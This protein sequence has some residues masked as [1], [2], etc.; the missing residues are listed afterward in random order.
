MAAWDWNYVFIASSAW[1]AINIIL[2]SIFY[3]EPT[4]E[5]HSENP[6]TFK[7]VLE[8]MVEVLGNGRFF[9]IIFVLL[10]ILVLGSK[11]TA[12]GYISWAEITILSIMWV[13]LNYL[14]DFIIK[15][16]VGRDSD[17][18]YLE[19][20]RLA[21]WKFGLYLLLMSGLWT[22]FNQIFYTL[23]LYIRDFVDT[24]DLMAAS[25]SLMDTIGLA[26]F[27]PA[28]KS[29]MVTPGQINPEYIIN[30]DAGAIILFQVV[31][32]VLVGRMQPFTT[33]FWGVVITVASFV[34]LVRGP[35][36]IYLVVCSPG[37]CML[38]LR[39][40]CRDLI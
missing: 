17:H 32:S 7:K 6:R 12:I 35:W 24:S 13:V 39:A 33:I 28:F 18:W 21:D 22:C 31:V 29:A 10:I 3:R 34:I 36:G 2:V 20:V 11:L 15:K 25:V 5:S 30:I 8:D 37:R 14:Y 19:P 16:R 38:F 40:I 23:P 26:S 1:I 4:S 27:V 9:L